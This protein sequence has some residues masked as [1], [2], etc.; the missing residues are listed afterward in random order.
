MRKGVFEM[1]KYDVLYVNGKVFT[2]DKENLYAES[3]AVKDGKI[4][5][6]GNDAEA[7]AADAEKTVDLGGRRVLPGFVD[8]HMHAIMLADCCRQIS[9]LPPAVNSIEE[10]VEEIKKV[11]GQQEA[12]Q[13]IFGWGY[14]EGK[15]AEHRAPNRYDLD[16]GASDSPVMVKR[17]CGHICAVNSKALE[18]AGVT[19]DTPDPE[20]GKIGRDENGEPDGILYEN[21]RNL[22]DGIMKTKTE[23]DMVDDLMALDEILLS[24]GVTTGADM[25]EFGGVDFKSVYGKAIDKGFHIRV[26]AYPM[27]DE[28][29]NDETFTITEEDQNPDNQ[30]RMAGVKL[31]G[32]GSVS[33]R[34]AWCDVPYLDREDPTKLSDEYGIPVCTPEDIEKAKAFCKKHHCQLSYHAMG[35]RTIDRAVGAGYGEKSWLKDTFSKT[36]YLRIEHVAMP[37]ADAIKK[38]A[39]A[40]IAFVTQPIFLYAEIESYLTNMGLERTQKNYPIKDFIESGVQFAFSTDAPATAW[41]TPSEPFACLKGAVT[42]KAYDGTDCGQENKVDIETAII[43]YTAES[44]PML[45]FENVGMLKD[46]F[47]ADF[48]VLDKDVLNIP[49]D[50]IDTVTVEETYVAGECVYKK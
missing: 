10:L 27:W 47:A 3:F 4:A 16:K 6:V 48:I 8:S 38:A 42:R 37:T 32:D 26:A 39:E 49:A 33:G 40:G 50:D 25:G 28:V 24:Q 7:P 21:A 15:L 19:K 35:A 31:I 29:K 45:G 2:S 11:R 22:L 46:G 44:A 43:L 23:D 17:T 34:T 12:G 1:K 5:W 36:P 41:A 14:D 13:W 30:F 20:G 9:A 18:M